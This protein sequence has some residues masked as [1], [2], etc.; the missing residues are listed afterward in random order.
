MYDGYRATGATSFFYFLSLM[1]FGQ[2]I[3][4]NIF[5]VREKKRHS[6]TP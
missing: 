2:F 6:M 4:M 3:V 5:L 1:I